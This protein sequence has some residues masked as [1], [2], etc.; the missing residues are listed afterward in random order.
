M[1]RV[2]RGR[3][4][5]RKS[6]WSNGSG[7]CVEI[8]GLR[9]GVGIRDSKAA[10]GPVLLLAPEQWTALVDALKAGDHDLT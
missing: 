3:V 8:A 2:A 10:T 5:W 7:N 9:S 6:S 4:A 1:N